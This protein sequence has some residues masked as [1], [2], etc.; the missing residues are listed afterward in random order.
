MNNSR[1]LIQIKW[2]AIFL[3][4]FFTVS[5]VAEFFFVKRQVNHTTLTLDTDDL[6]E[7]QVEGREKPIR[8][9]RVRRAS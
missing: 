8:V 3:A 2:L 7:I 4:A 5:G 1:A 9:Y 6:G